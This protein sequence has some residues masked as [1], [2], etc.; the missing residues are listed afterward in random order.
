MRTHRLPFLLVLILAVGGCSEDKP[1]AVPS[2]ATGSP[3]STLL[4][5]SPPASTETA[6]TSLRKACAL[7]R[8]GFQ[9]D[10]G[11]ELA[12]AIADG[13]LQVPSDFESLLAAAN[14]P[15]DPFAKARA[16]RDAGFIDEAADELKKA[17][18]STAEPVPAELRDLRPENLRVVGIGTWTEFRRRMTSFAIDLAQLVGVISAAVL[19]LLL[20]GL[21][22]RFVFRATVGRSVAVREALGRRPTVVVG[23]LGEDDKI[24]TGVL[25]RIREEF[26]NLESEA[27]GIRRRPR[28]G[29]GRTTQVARPRRRLAP[30][31]VRRCSLRSRPA[32][33]PA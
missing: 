7:A 21:L 10:A 23:P 8:A 22:V 30:V 14:P 33:R 28:Q 16:L 6:A 11:K 25:A 15:G 9:A 4:A 20:L 17:V 5:Q 12:A 31:E 2:A 3:C 18:T 1:D 26:R 19:I 24:S 32:I 29:A 27:G 13:T